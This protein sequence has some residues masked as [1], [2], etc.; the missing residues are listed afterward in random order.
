MSDQSQ[1][2]TAART[3]FRDI[4]P[5]VQKWTG[6]SLAR[7]IKEKGY[8]GTADAHN[9]ALT[10]CAY[11]YG[12]AYGETVKE[13]AIEQATRD[14]MLLAI[15]QAKTDLVKSQQQ[16]TAERIA[17]AATESHLAKQRE[18][19]REKVKTLGEFLRRCADH[20]ISGTDIADTPLPTEQEWR[21]IFA[22]AKMEDAK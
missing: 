14:D 11:Y 6:L 5:Q 1:H 9:T 15:V 7:L 20:M 8:Q 4:A 19:E 17:H 22:L 3:D 18:A 2:S 12:Q 16:L 21:E 13:L 10:F